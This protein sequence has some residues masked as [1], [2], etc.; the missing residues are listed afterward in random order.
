MAKIKIVGLVTLVTG[1]DESVPPGTP[2]ALDKA[3]AAALI[4]RGLAAPHAEPKPVPRPAG[5]GGDNTGGKDTEG[6]ADNAQGGGE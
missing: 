2:V 3:E 6:A 1:P 5:G 4:A